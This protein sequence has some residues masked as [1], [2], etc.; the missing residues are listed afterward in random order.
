VYTPSLAHV[1]GNAVLYFAFPFL[2]RV[3]DLS[4]TTSSWQIVAACALHAVLVAML[5]RRFGA[6]VAVAYAC[7]YLVFLVPLLAIRARSAHYLYAAAPV[8]ALALALLFD[9]AR[10]RG[11]RVAAGFLVACA[12]LLVA[13]TLRI[14]LY[15]HETG[16]CQSR[17]LDSVD[18]L[19]SSGGPATRLR[20]TGDP[21]VPLDVGVRAVHGRAVYEGAG[22]RRVAFER[23][24][25]PVD[26]P[27]AV[28]TRAARMTRSCT[29]ELR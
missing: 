5:A 9:D 29:I 13:H 7:G 27:A 11:R 23:D 10:R 18:R 12:L 20:I 19:L 26:G 2:L 14:Q 24:G 21:D 1:A 16:R 15:L 25:A 6:R 28:D 4:G 22:G 8:L 17:F 3:D